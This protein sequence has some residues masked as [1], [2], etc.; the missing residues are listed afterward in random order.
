M[1][2]IFLIYKREFLNLVRKRSF[3]LATFLV[4]LGMAAI[5][6]FQVYFSLN[7]DQETYTVLV[8]EDESFEITQR[9]SSDETYQVTFSPLPLDSL[10]KQVW[11]DKGLILL[12]LGEQILEKPTG[13]ATLYNN[14]SLNLSVV[15]A[16]RRRLETAVRSYKQEQAG[17]ATAQLEQMDFEL[18]VDSVVSNAKEEKTGSELV[19]MIA[20][21]GLSLLMYML[22]AIYGGMLMQGVIDEK[23]SRIV[24]VIVSSVKPFQ[25][26]LGKVLAIAS[27]GIFQLLLWVISMMIISSI[28][29]LVMAGMVDPDQ[30]MAMNATGMESELALSEMDKVIGQLQSFNWLI[31]V[32][33]FP[34]YF[35][36]GFFLYGSLFAA[37]GASVDNVQDAQQLTLPITLPMLVPV[38]LVM[39]IVQNPNS[40]LAT[41]LSLVPFSSPMAML[42]RLSTTEVPVWQVLLSLLLL[43]GGF[44]GCIWVAARIYRTGILMYGKKPGFGELWRWIRYRA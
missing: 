32:W 33:A 1:N 10:K 7:V 39:N 15:E 21:L 20:G 29:M 42:V 28:L 6:G 17:I 26:L 35:L 2:K 36:G 8:S 19:A 30:V 22:V 34:V 37:V 23:S 24:E 13:H 44:L 38:M 25:L 5:M 43:V 41:V 4:P 3:W 18:S 14:S 27:V 11:E 40:L 12:D 16:V 9:L 31:L